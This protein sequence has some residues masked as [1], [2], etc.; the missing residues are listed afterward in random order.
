VTTEA[1]VA[2]AIFTFTFVGILSGKVHRT[3]AG[4]VGAAVMVMAGLAMDFYT[5]EE[6]LAAIDF[7]TIGLLMGMMILVGLLEQTGFFQYMAITAG[8]LSRGSPWLLLVALGTTT[9]VLSMFLDNV[10]TIVLIAPVTIRIAETLGIKVVPL[11]MAE[12]LLSNTGGVATLVGD[13]P[14]IVIASAAGFSFIDFLTHS[15]PVVLVVWPAALLSLRI[16]FRR[17][18]AEKARHIEALMEMRAGD[19][20]HDRVALRRTLI[21]FAVVIVMFFLHEQFHLSPAFVAMAGASAGLL[22][23][24]TGVERAL[25]SALESVEWSVL[26]F[27]A[28]LLRDGGRPR[29]VGAARGHRHA[30]GRAGGRESAAGEPGDAVDGLDR[31]RHRGQHPVHDRHG[32][33]HRAARRARDRNVAV[34]VGARLRGRLW[35]Q[36]HADRVHGQRG[37]GDHERAHGHAHHHAHVAALRVGGHARH[38]RPGDAGVH[39]AVRARLAHHPM[40]AAPSVPRSARR[41]QTAI[42][43]GWRR[44]ARGLP[45]MAGARQAIVVGR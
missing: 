41:T 22:W 10:T 11:L 25:E 1:A 31:L 24:G 39:P 16:V 17:E 20:L 44:T 26:L 7:N 45:S 23:V 36:R 13:P 15:L 42:G 38:D 28:A 3:V 21:V 14:N 27:F 18:L 9:T 32:A 37:G 29:S 2:I 34:V 40:T 33:D 5:E 35:R 12:A 4:A 19:A 8:Q 6:A 43:H 30:G